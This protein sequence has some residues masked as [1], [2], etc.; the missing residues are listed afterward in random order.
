MP[1]PSKRKLQVASRKRDE[2]G[3]FSEFQEQRQGS[4]EN[5]DDD[6]DRMQI[7]ENGEVWCAEDFREFQNIETR[8]EL[9]WKEDAL[10]N[11]RVHYNSTSRTTQWRKRKAEE[12]LKKHVHSF[13]KIDT[14]FRPS[15]LILK[16]IPE[17]LNSISVTTIRKFARKSWR[18]MD[19][20][21]IGLEGRMAEWAVKKYKSH[22][23]LPDNI[24]EFF[25]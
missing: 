21:D 18:Y 13:A 8:F 12:E 9:V 4:I 10:K 3:S 20:Y 15:T 16:I 6:D 5:D 17:V 22:R 7:L 24:N 2:N 11:K 14:F 1:R 23:R 19:A 25:E